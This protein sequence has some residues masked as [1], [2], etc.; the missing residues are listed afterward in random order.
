MSSGWNLSAVLAAVKV[1]PILSLSCNITSSAAAPGYCW[2]AGLLAPGPAARLPGMGDGGTACPMLT[3]RGSLKHAS[4]VCNTETETFPAPC[5]ALFGAIGRSAAVQGLQAGPPAALGGVFAGAACRQ[6]RAVQMQCSA[7]QCSSYFR[8]P[9]M[10]GSC[11]GMD[12]GRQRAGARCGHTALAGANGHWRAD[13]PFAASR[14]YC[15]MLRIHSV[16]SSFRI[17]RGFP[18]AEPEHPA[19]IELRLS[20]AFGRVKKLTSSSKI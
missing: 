18:S 10:S 19:K 8:Q 1:N 16:D 20:L 2:A 14:A 17:T 6:G 4:A 3:W 5:T 7:V 12:H 15:A 13:R 9:L 11:L